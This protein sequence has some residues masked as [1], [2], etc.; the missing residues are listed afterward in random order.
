MK[1]R[2]LKFVDALLEYFIKDE[3]LFTKI[4]YL[5][6]EIRKYKCKNIN[7][8][9]NTPECIL[10]TF[11]NYTMKDLVN[12]ITRKFSDKKLER[13]VIFIVNGE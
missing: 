3:I 6:H 12:I 10:N 9:Q 5:R 13:W 2:V 1:D 4:L 11:S 8:K 7:L